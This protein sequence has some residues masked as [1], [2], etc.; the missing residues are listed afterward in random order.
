MNTLVDLRSLARDVR[1]VLPAIQ[2]PAL[3]P[4]AITTWSG[5]MKNE[6]GS[7]R[8]FEAL[9]LQ[10]DAAGLEGTAACR[11]FAAE[12][13][14]HGVLCGA[15][16]EA[17]GA[18]AVFEQEPLS[19]PLHHDVS[20]TEGALRNVLSI[21]CL[22]ETVAVALIGAER[23]AMQ[24]GQLRDTLETILADEIGHARFGWKLMADWVP[25]LAVEGRARLTRYLAVAF[26]ALERHQLA[27]ISPVASPAADAAELG[28][29]DGH[30]MRALFYATV[31]QVI[32]PRLCALGIEASGAWRARADV[33]GAPGLAA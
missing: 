16:V 9:A 2:D 23:L 11:A 10:L 32:G 15:V 24:P 6:H 18:P 33:P 31:K 7:A 12:E 3:M 28:V 19:F 4:H 17:L 13:R 21:A 14:R 8:V 25:R 29:C 1:P 27:N 30:E 22:S 20:P 5:R 26:A